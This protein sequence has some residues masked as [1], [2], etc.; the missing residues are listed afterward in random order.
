MEM[1]LRQGRRKP[2]ENHRAERLVFGPRVPQTTRVAWSDDISGNDSPSGATLN[3]L[4]PLLTGY[5]RHR[6]R[7][8]EDVH[9]L[10]QE[11]FLRLSQRGALVE[12]ANLR[13]YA[14]QVAESVLTDRQRRRAVRHA[15]AHVE[16]DPERMAEPA[17]AP[18]RIIAGRETLNAVL[19]AL[20]QLPDRTR[21]IFVLRRI[22]GM[23][24]L[25]ISKRL[26]ISVSAV[27]KHMVRAVAHL[28]SV[29]D[30]R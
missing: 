24:Y 12:I 9:D 30:L 20:N 21:T 19:S 11:V 6:V 28:A 5:F 16:L 25:D 23:R 27:E 1:L 26:G 2:S 14:F 15:D 18:D 4:R 8:Q 22:E 13:G 29:G 7:E 10:V 3:A 17:L